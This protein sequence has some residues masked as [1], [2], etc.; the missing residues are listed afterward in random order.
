MKGISSQ[1]NVDSTQ[2]LL[3]Q[4]LQAK[5]EK[6]YALTNLCGLFTYL[7]LTG[8]SNLPVICLQAPTKEHLSSVRQ[9]LAGDQNRPC[10]SNVEAT[11]HSYIPAGKKPAAGRKTSTILAFHFQHLVVCFYLNFCGTQ[12]MIYTWAVLWAV[13]TEQPRRFSLEL[14]GHCS[15]MAGGTWDKLRQA[16]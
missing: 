10:T 15:S 1:T 2:T 11:E 5:H 7:I 13:L 8:F 6:H 4:Y 9:L 12:H 3:I 16:F 14:P